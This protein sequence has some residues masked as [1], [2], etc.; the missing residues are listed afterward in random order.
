VSVAAIDLFQQRYSCRSFSTEPV[1]RETVRTLLEAACWAPNA[2]NMQPW[3]FI[4][5]ED[6]ARRRALAAAALNQGF[7]AEAPVVIVVCAVPEESARTYGQRGRELYC[8][9]DTAAA[10]ENLLLAA[11]ALGLG[12]CWVG[13]FS[14]Q[15][16]SRVLGID[17]HSMRPVAL[18]PVGHAAQ[19]PGSRS[20]LPLDHVVRWDGS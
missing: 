10:T 9:Q 11:T 15:L 17:Q 12:S 8:L 2:G 1:P 18:V 3:R 14:E 19:G 4:V 13:A 16:V 5:V 20:R 6:T 7:I